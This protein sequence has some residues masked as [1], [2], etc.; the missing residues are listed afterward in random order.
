MMKK[1]NMQLLIIM[2]A[3][4]LSKRTTVHLVFNVQTLIFFATDIIICDPPRDFME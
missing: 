4:G 1:K 2:L 3:K